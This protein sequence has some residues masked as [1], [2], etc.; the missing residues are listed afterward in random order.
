MQAAVFVKES[1]VDTEVSK[2]HIDSQRFKAAL[3]EIVARI[4]S[5]VPEF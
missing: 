3:E 2:F 5:F 4:S 1:Q